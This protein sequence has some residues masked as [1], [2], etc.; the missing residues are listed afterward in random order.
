MK[1]R[2]VAREVVENDELVLDVNG[3]YTFILVPKHQK[4]STSN[5]KGGNSVLDPK[6]CVQFAIRQEAS[7]Q[8]SQWLV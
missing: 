6:K 1:D 4:S 2:Y 8:V 3:C 5:L 7:H